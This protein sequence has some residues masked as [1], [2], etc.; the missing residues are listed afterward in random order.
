MDKPF[1]LKVTIVLITLLIIF[2]GCKTITTEKE[3]IN[4]NIPSYQVNEINDH[5]ITLNNLNFDII[6]EEVYKIS[7]NFNSIPEENIIYLTYWGKTPTAEIQNNE[8]SLFI[9]YNN[10]EIEGVYLNFESQVKTIFFKIQEMPANYS[11]LYK[12]NHREKVTVQIPEVYELCNIIYTLIHKEKYDEIFSNDKYYLNVI[13]WFLPHKNHEIFLKLKDVNYSSLVE[14]GA[15]YIF[16]GD[17]I[18]K[19]GLYSGFRAKDD[20]KEITN[21]LEDFAKTSRF[22]EFYK[23]HQNYYTNLIQKFENNVKAKRIW[24]WLESQFPARYQSYKIFFSPLGCGKHSARNFGSEKFKESI[25]FLSGPNLQD[26][27]KESPTIKS[28]MMSRSFFTEADHPYVNPVSDQYI[29]EIN[30]AFK[31]LALWC[32]KNSGYYTP[33][34]TFNEYMTWSIFSL[35]A[36]ENYS[37]KDYKFIKDYFEDFMKEGR[38]FYKFK[39]FNDELIRQYTA[40][41][42]KETIT[43]LYPGII[44][45]IKN[46]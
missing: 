18:K 15:S 10:K 8:N 20:V 11:E 9:T 16:K 17:K 38:G 33:Y 1:N 35:Y 14:N 7:K 27:K 43:N 30:S 26:S 3:K 36:M 28:A 44:N 37:I 12:K 25:L 34:L 13:D 45:W 29:E 19:G 4:H 21:Y 41:T 31:D 42:S 46:N 5:Y 23:N 6:I 39:E 2:A 22:K 32:N 40:K 24:N